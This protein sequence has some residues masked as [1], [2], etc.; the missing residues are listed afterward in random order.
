LN[1]TREAMAACGYCPS[2]RLF[3][4]AACG[5]PLLSDEW[6]GLDEFFSPG[7]EIL[8]ARSAEDTLAALDLSDTE[9]RTIAGAARERVLAEHTAAH[10]AQELERMLDE[11]LCA[12][13]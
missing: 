10:R 5:A 6:E 9:L 2:G 7:S 4:A 3:E 11:A 8:L 12:T 1:V 13:V